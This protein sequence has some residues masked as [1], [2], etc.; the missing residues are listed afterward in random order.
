MKTLHADDFLSSNNALERM[1]TALES[2]PA[3]SL[4]ASARQIVDEKSRTG[5]DV[6]VLRTEPANCRHHSDQS[7]SLRAAQSDRW[8]EC[9]HVSAWARGARV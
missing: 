5:R 8:A 7:M 2:N 4:V 1:V 6:V 3:V 9:G